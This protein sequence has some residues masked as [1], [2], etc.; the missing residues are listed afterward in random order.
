MVFQVRFST[1]LFAVLCLTHFGP[2]SAETLRWARSSDALTLDP[3]AQNEGPTHTILHQIYEPLVLRNSAGE[4]EA[5]LATEWRVSPD[6][7]DTWVLQLRKGVTFHD[8]A[9]FDATDVIFSLE[10]AM[11]PQSNVKDVLAS[12][13]EISSEGEHIVKITT[14]GP[15]PL[16]VNNLT[17]VFMMDKEWTEA[18]DA[19]EVQDFESGEQTFSSQYTNGTGAYEL[20]SRQIDQK[21]VLK[22]YNGYWGKGIFPLDITDVVYTPIQSSATRLAAFLSD[23]VDFIQ[24]IPVQDLAKVAAVDGLKV[25]TAPQN[26]VIFLGMNIGD[27]D[28]SYD[29]IDGENPFQKREVRQAI[30]I[31]IDRIAIQ[32]IVM[33]NQSSPTGI[34]APPF[35][36]GWTPEFDLIPEFNLVHAKELMLEAGYEDGFSITLN[37]PN[38]RYI[39]DEAI[40]LSVVG[41]LAK[42]GIDVRLDSL[43]KAQHF[44]IINNFE[45]DFYLLGWGIPTF[46]SEYIFNFLVHT[47]NDKYGSWNSTRFS[48]PELDQKIESLA[49]ITDLSVRNEII[50]DIWK[51]VQDKIMYIP[52][53]NQVLNWGIKSGIQTEVQPEDQPKLKYFSVN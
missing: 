26:R 39:N 34:I 12:I 45:T 48:D 9:V 18:N 2:A 11:T 27:A 33:R 24:D 50:S 32:K 21:T 4:V 31:A 22:A 7:P 42:I 36:N 43:P 52:I 8:G 49:K 41:M 15:N 53:H 17:T 13:I 29:N 5:A 37:C 16:L 14:D 47:K 23:E 28:L 19:I 35:V 44:P 30:N 3:H 40:C 20:V 38:D 1:V 51:S 10:R 25:L 6:D 46:D